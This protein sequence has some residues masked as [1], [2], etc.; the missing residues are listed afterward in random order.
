MITI[1]NEETKKII[2]ALK[3]IVPINFD[4]MDRLVAVVNYFE[5]QLAITQKQEQQ[6][7]EAET[8]DG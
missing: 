7:Q 8:K 3:G 4:G 6:K 1:S 5:E 2:I